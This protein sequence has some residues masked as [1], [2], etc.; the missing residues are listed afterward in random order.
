VALHG[1]RDACIAAL[2][3]HLPQWRFAVPDG[4]M[5]LW[6]HVPGVDAD[7]FARH[8]L[9][10]GVQITAGSAMSVQGAASEYLRISY[11]QTGVVW[12]HAAQRLKQAWESFGSL[13]SPKKE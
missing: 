3:Q 2:R 4:G 9:T 7:A 1:Q 6:V 8:A 5:F 10:Y 13:N 12:E 11:A